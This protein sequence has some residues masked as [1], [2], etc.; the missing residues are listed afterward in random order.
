MSWINDILKPESWTCFYKI[1]LP[2]RLFQT[3]D[4]KKRI[5]GL[6]KK[7]TFRFLNQFLLQLLQTKLS[8][9][10]DS[11]P[12][13]DQAYQHISFFVFVTRTQSSPLLNMPSWNQQQ[14]AS[15]YLRINPLALIPLFHFLH[16]A[17]VKQKHVINIS[18][19]INRIILII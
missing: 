10:W 3:L 6:V 14:T 12:K 15:L 16:R 8:F 13:S 1:L 18:L 11:F 4:N 5:F 17:D 2:N 9:L 19:I 7:E